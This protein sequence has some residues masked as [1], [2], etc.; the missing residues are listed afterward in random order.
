MHQGRGNYSS[1]MSNR[2]LSCQQ[3]FLYVTSHWLLL[4]TIQ[5]CLFCANFQG[6]IFSFNTAF[7]NPSAKMINIINR[8]VKNRPLPRAQFDFNMALILLLYVDVLGMCLQQIPEIMETAKT[9]GNI[10]FIAYTLLSSGSALKQECAP[11]QAIVY[12]YV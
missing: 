1:A 11:Q 10:L 6:H 3:P 4:Y 7:K 9:M 8:P 2:S 5:R 12:R